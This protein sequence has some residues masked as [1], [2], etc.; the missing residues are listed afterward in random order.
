[1]QSVFQTFCTVLMWQDFGIGG[2]TRLEVFSTCNKVSANCLQ[3]G[4]AAD[5]S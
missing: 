4:L 5:Y 1:M 2:P 3:G